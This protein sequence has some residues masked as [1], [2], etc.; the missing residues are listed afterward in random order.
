[1][2]NANAPIWTEIE[3]GLKYT[4]IQSPNNKN[5]HIYILSFDPK[6]FQFNLYSISE[7]K[8]KA[9]TLKQWAKQENLIAAI[10]ASMYLP[11]KITSTGYMRNKQH[12][13]N[14]HIAK[15]FGAF[16]VSKP[17][18]NGDST[19]PTTN[20]LDKDS[21]N[22]QELI[23]KYEIVVQNFRLINSKKE[24]L[25]KKNKTLFSISAIGKDYNGNIL[26]IHSSYAITPYK[27]AQ[28]LLQ[29]P[30][31]IN[32]VMYTE[33]GHQA[34]LLINVPNMTQF[35]HGNSLV[36]FLIPANID[37]LLPNIMGVTRKQ[38]KPAPILPD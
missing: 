29:A 6:I 16:L 8:H 11:D 32:T 31:N 7:K 5:E 26:L 2:A 33:G 27:F 4:E 13:N 37:A 19:L 15:S 14:K 21:D 28:L 36:D 25:W 34:G 10:N 1:M 12:L 30:I 9:L 38:V 23:L 24:I 35:W 17:Y 18:A 22:W 20:I 3:Y